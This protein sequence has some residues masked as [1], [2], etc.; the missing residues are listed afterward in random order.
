[1]FTVNRI[2]LSLVSLL[3]MVSLSVPT[4]AQQS[5]PQSAA[6]ASKQNSADQETQPCAEAEA[7]KKNAQ[8]L[9]AEVQRLRAR[10]VLLEK[11]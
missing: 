6:D 4:L 1:M 11:D 3:F 7:L 5:Q 10:V 2:P 8:Q 9:S